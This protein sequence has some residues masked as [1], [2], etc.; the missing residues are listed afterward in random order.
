MGSRRGRLQAPRLS[1]LCAGV[2]PP[3]PAPPVSGPLA[4]SHAPH[5]RS[6]VA[7]R[8]T[9]TLTEALCGPRGVRGRAATAPDGGTVGP[10]VAA[11]ESGNHAPARSVAGCGQRGNAG[12]RGRGRGAGRREGDCRRAAPGRDAMPGGAVSER[13]GRGSGRGAAWVPS[14]SG[15]RPRPSH[16]ESEYGPCNSLVIQAD[17]LPFDNRPSLKLGKAL[18]I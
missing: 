12:A 11:D 8:A 7:G 2:L 17:T 9:V 13:G 15:Q 1:L 16:T 4:S 18:G 10:G 14:V 6:K 5:R 3:F